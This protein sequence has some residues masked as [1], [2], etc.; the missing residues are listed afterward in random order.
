MSHD[1]RDQDTC[2]REYSAAYSSSSSDKEEKKDFS[3]MHTGAQ[4]S[5]SEYLQSV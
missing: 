4:L 3:L 1:L 5:D 2:M